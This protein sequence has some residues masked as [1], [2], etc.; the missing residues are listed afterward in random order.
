MRKPLIIATAAAVALL[1]GCQAKQST[2]PVATKEMA[3][4]QAIVQA[5]AAKANFLTHDG[6]TA[7]LH[8]VAP[9]GQGAA[10]QTCIQGFVAKDGLL[11]HSQRERFKADLAT[12]IV[13]K[14]STVTTKKGKHS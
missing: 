7:F 6:R 12:C 5:C 14:T 11:T 8:C 1:A 3:Q 2:N 13:P 9:P 4:A 10:V